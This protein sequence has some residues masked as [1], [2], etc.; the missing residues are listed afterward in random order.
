MFVNLLWRSVCDEFCPSNAMRFS[1]DA[2][3]GYWL[4][5]QDIVRQFDDISGQSTRGTW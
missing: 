1:S 3:S 2:D 5:Q 4:E